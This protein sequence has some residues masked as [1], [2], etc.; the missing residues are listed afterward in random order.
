L[1]CPPHP[2]LLQKEKNNE[3]GNRTKKKCKL[4][5]P[6][7]PASVNLEVLPLPEHMRRLAPFSA[8]FFFSLTAHCDA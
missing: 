3:I 8:I 7:I 5:H 2:W 6:S 4:T 1:Y